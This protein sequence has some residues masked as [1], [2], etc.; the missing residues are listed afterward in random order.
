MEGLVKDLNGYQGMKES[1]DGE[2]ES[3]AWIEDGLQIFCQQ[4]KSILAYGLVINST[5]LGGAKGFQFV[6]FL[7]PISEAE[8]TLV[9]KEGVNHLLA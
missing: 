1:K 9:C 8:G 4:P 3:G 2:R 6:Y 5:S 7:L